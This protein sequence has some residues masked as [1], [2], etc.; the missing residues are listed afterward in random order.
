MKP[1]CVNDL[2]GCNGRLTGHHLLV[3]DVFNYSAP[4]EYFQ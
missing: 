4:S 2:F 1:H 3:I